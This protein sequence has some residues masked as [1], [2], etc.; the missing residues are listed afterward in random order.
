MFPQSPGESYTLE[1]MTTAMLGAKTIGAQ[2][3]T[4]LTFVQS[5]CLLDIRTNVMPAF[6]HTM[7][8]ADEAC[9]SDRKGHTLDADRRRDR[10]R[11][12]AGGHLVSTTLIILY[13][14]G[15]L[16]ELWLVLPSGSA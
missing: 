11:G 3:L 15:G 13:G 6:L 1:W 7:K 8:I 9:G 12:G 14:T 4:G 2:S 5:S 16:P 10:D